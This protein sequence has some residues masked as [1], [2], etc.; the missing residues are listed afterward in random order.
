MYSLRTLSRV[1]YG[2]ISQRCESRNGVAGDK[3]VRVLV[4]SRRDVR[5]EIE[6][7][8]YYIS[9]RKVTSRR[10]VRVEISFGIH[11]ITAYLS[12]ISQRCESRN[13]YI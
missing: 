11:I 13:G 1:E 7:P 8:Y 4:T 2:H 9:G 5:V 3:N 12:H 10:D 6:Q